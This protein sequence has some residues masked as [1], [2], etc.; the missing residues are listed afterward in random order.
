MTCPVDFQTWLLLLYKDRK[1]RKGPEVMLEAAQLKAILSNRNSG[2]T[3]VCHQLQ[4]SRS[5]SEA[6]QHKDKPRAAAAKAKPRAA[7]S[8]ANS[9][10]IV[11]KI[12]PRAA[13]AKTT[14]TPDSWAT[15]H[16][17]KGNR[18]CKAHVT[19]DSY[20]RLSTLPT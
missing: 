9:R 8:K 15:V 5:L 14:I 1:W 16:P 7:A 10:T 18:L 20:S 12:K 4:Q 11:A 2:T 13:A 19:F 3:D 17:I 6:K